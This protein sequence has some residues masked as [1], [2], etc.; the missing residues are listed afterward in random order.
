MHSAPSREGFLL[1]A[2][3][4]SMHGPVWGPESSVTMRW[5]DV[6]SSAKRQT[7]WAQIKPDGGCTL[8]AL[9]STCACASVMGGVSM[10]AAPVHCN[11]GL[12]MG[13]HGP[14]W[15]DLPVDSRRWK[16]PLEFPVF[17][18]RALPRVLLKGGGGGSGTPN[19]KSLCPTNS[20]KQYFRL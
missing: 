9:P 8:N 3:A 1:C 14:E 18:F 11:P 10:N 7:V 17:G 5:L 20:P 16:A 19:A 12:A 2:P 6:H 13:C 15:S 4:N